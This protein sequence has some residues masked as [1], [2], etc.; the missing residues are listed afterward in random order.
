[1]Q[2]SCS[3][4]WLLPNAPVQGTQASFAK[5]N[6]TQEHLRSKTTLACLGPLQRAVRQLPLFEKDLYFASVDWRLPK[7]TGNAWKLCIPTRRQPA[8]VCVATFCKNFAAT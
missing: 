5:G 1:M 7:N 4:T 6:Q 8:I 3:Q 2:E